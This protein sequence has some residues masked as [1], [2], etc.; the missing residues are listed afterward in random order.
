M[1]KRGVIILILVILLIGS[2]IYIGL[3]VIRDIQTKKL[4]T[5]QA[6]YQRGLQDGFQFAVRQ[7]IKQA[8]TCN[9]VPLYADNLTINVFALECLKHNKTTNITS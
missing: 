4:M 2:L 7:V 1:D 9:A 5:Q 6:I 8:M 3:N